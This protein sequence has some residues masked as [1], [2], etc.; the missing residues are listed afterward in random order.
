MFFYA[1]KIISALI[2]PSSVIAMLLVVGAAGAITGR[3]AL[4]SR[5][6]LATGIFLLLAC[7]FGP[8]GNILLL[9]L[10]ERFVRGPLPSDVQGAIILGGFEM[11]T[12]TQ[13][14]GQLSL[15]EAGERLT[16]GVRVA[17]ERPKSTLIYTGGEARLLGSE[18][19][20][21]AA[22]IGDMFVA[23]GVPRERIVLEDLS[24]TTWENADKL[25][26][27]VKP[28]PGQRFVL[29]TSAFHMPRAMGTFRAAGFDVTAWPVDYRT[30]GLVDA[31]KPHTS[32]HHGLQVLDIAFKEWVGLAA[33]RM[34]G[35]SA[36]FWPG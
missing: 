17:L 36:A 11:G 18:K 23:F 34:S 28:Q 16:E 4:W 14:R 26:A 3:S 27:I 20:E 5:R 7:G 21:A 31:L 19:S 29:V 30:A 22:S 1:S 24:R 13:A 25:R 9:P 10:E 15:N 2:W 8:L 12:M 35:R 32:V 6:A 33:Y